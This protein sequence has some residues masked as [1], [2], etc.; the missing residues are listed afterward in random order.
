MEEDLNLAAAGC[1]TLFVRDDVLWAASDEADGDS[2]DISKG[3]AHSRDHVQSF[4][5]P[6]LFC[7]AR[8]AAAEA[9]HDAQRAELC[10]LVQ[11]ESPDQRAHR[12]DDATIAVRL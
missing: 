4:S 2:A 1:G 6:C 7:R 12:H 10:A 3:W 8:K 11:Q 5:Q 9:A